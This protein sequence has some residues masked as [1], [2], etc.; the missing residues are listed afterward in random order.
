[1][2]PE[3]LK[4]YWAGVKPVVPPQIEYRLHYNELGNIVMCSMVDH[5]E[6]LGYIVVTREQYE[7]Y[8]DYTIEN[9]R[10]KK[11][12]HDSGYRVKLVKSASGYCVVKNHA[13][14]LLEADETYKDIE[15]YG[16]R[17]N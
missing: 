14:L 8:F 17:T 9:G 10:L 11:I 13:G 15:Y 12:D 16:Y 5:P 7:R 3:E 4:E 1:M 2:S 6:S